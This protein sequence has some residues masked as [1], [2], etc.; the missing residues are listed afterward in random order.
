MGLS[1]CCMALFPDI[2]SLVQY[3]LMFK[4]KPWMRNQIRKKITPS[5]PTTDTSISRNYTNKIYIFKNTAWLHTCMFIAWWLAWVNK[6]SQIHARY[7]SF[8]LPYVPCFSMKSIY[9]FSCFPNTRQNEEIR[10]IHSF[11][12]QRFLDVLRLFGKWTQVP[13]MYT[14]HFCPQSRS[15]EEDY[16]KKLVAR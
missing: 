9:T 6:P 10:S 3:S 11:A 7:R 12:M 13:P 15:S 14:L 1:Q 5:N 4:H 8:T 2:T 16:M